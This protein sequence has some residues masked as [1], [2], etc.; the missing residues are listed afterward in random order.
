MLCFRKS[1]VQRQYCC[2]TATTN[3]PCCLR[4]MQCMRESGSREVQWGAGEGILAEA[5]WLASAGPDWRANREPLDSTRQ[6]RTCKAR[7]RC[8]AGL[9]LLLRRA[10][11][12][13]A[14][15]AVRLAGGGVV[16]CG[17][18]GKK[19]EPS[20]VWSC[21]AL[22]R[23]RDRA[24]SDPA[25]VGAGSR[26]MRVRA[27]AIAR[28]TATPRGVCK[29]AALAAPGREVQVQCLKQKARGHAARFC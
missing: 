9:T 8:G 2:T 15:A 16:V 13:A 4:K 12:I 19:Q 3:A 10:A 28:E 11:T 18:G 1:G 26:A 7:G 23:D 22:C 14:I 25:A 27:V 5:M 21:A 17:G 6:D 20:W 29:S 24:Q